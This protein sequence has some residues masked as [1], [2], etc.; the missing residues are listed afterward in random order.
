VK[1][2]ITAL[3]DKIIENSEDTFSSQS[4]GMIMLGLQKQK[5]ASKEIQ[6]SAWSNNIVLI[7]T[8]FNNFI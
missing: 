1:S 4:I 8:T 5:G 6:R 2:I 7:F 3:T